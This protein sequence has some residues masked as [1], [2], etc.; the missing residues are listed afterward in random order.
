MVLQSFSGEDA[1]AFNKRRPSVAISQ[2]NLPSA[3]GLVD[4][5]PYL[6]LRNCHDNV[7]F[8]HPAVSETIV[9]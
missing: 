9:H 7:C 1:A 4:S 8:M 6:K 2:T 3:C 5:L